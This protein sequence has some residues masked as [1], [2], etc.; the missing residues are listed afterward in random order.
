M[1]PTKFQFIWSSGFT[2]EDFSRNRPIR[3]KNC[4]LRPCLLTELD[5]MRNLIEDLP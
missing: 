3:N 5:E 1:L 4:L 2:G